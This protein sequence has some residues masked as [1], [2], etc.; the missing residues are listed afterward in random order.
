[1]VRGGDLRTDASVAAEVGFVALGVELDS[2]LACGP[3]NARSIL[4]GAD[5]AASSVMGLP[6]LL[7]PRASSQRRYELALDVT[8]ALGAPGALVGTGPLS[9]RTVEE[10]D[11]L[12]RRRLDELG[13]LAAARGVR[14]VLE[15]MHPLMRAWNY[16]HTLGHAAALVDGLEGVGIAVDTGHLWWDPALVPEFASHVDKIVTVQITDVRTEALA[17][18]RYE[19][20]KPGTGDVPVARHLRAFHDAGYRG[21]F[22]C[23]VLVRMPKEDRPRLLH[24][25]LAW[26]VRTWSDIA[27]GDDR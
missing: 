21:F 26:L 1:M 13:S 25:T 23:E 4:D 9:G 24:D 12:V 3:G 10:A 6:D 16:V 19:R 22:E 20:A 11:T 17:A 27:A 7:E 2:V 5:L 15:P 18:L 14:I 8:A